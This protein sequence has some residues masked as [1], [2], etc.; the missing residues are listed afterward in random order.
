ML[1]DMQVVVLLGGIGKRLKGIE[2]NRPKA[3]LD[4]HG[5]PFFSYQLKL[6]KEQGLKDFVFCVGHKAEVIKNYFKDGALFGVNIRYSYDGK[7]LLGTAGALRKALPSLKKDFMVIYGDSYMDVDYAEIAYNYYKVKEEENKKGLMVIFKNKNR[8][9]KSNV[10]F[11]DGKLLKYDKKKPSAEME[12]IDYGISLL[13]K[14]IVKKIPKDKYMDFSSVYHHLVEHEFMAGYEVRNRFYEIGTPSSLEE[15]KE[16]IYQR[17]FLKKRAI[18]LDRDGTLNQLRFNEATEELDSPL[19]AEELRLLPKTIPSLRI[20]KSLG[21]VIVVITNQPAA[22]KGK[23][24][25]GELYEVN[26][27]FKDILAK[28]NV[29]LDDVFLCP[30]HPIGSPSSRERF[31]IKTC[32]CRKPKPGLLKMAIKKFNVDVPHSYMVGDSYADVAAAQSVNMKGVYLGPQNSPTNERPL[33]RT[34]DYIF[35]SL[36][37]FAHFLKNNN[38]KN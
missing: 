12:H 29:T 15:F 5:T 24:T 25:L 8:Y 32:A 10:L 26:N 19:K 31:L 37:D 36:Y 2:S 13:N 35:K 28:R 21:Y 11:K 22:A 38:G 3:M 20:L 30:H 27:R 16:F 9:D 14:S 18:F 34:P 33:K 4:I 23:T 1:K 7:E 6:L 17:S